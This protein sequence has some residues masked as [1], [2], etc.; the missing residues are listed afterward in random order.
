MAKINVQDLIASAAKAAEEIATTVASDAAE[1]AA[2]ASKEARRAEALARVEFRSLVDQVGPK[3]AD[4]L[5]KESRLEKTIARITGKLEQ[6]HDR[7]GK[8]V[9][10]ILAIQGWVNEANEDKKVLGTTIN[11]LGFKI[12]K[13]TIEAKGFKDISKV[14]RDFREAMVEQAIASTPEIK[15]LVEVKEALTKKVEAVLA[16]RLA[17]EKSLFKAGKYLQLQVKQLDA[18]DCEVQISDKAVTEVLSELPIY[19]EYRFDFKRDYEIFTLSVRE[20]KGRIKTLKAAKK[21]AEKTTTSSAV[22]KEEAFYKD[23]CSDNIIS[24]AEAKE[25][26]AL[27]EAA[28]KRGNSKVLTPKTIE[29]AKKAL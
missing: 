16:K 26:Q 1:K 11:A 22:L 3:K 7:C 23:A 4:L 17:K 14:P 28:S 8:L 25:L 21:A 2:V 12:A 10:H 19:G 5:E 27:K 9:N 24:L 29:K 13:A 20:V 18:L 6:A 15:A